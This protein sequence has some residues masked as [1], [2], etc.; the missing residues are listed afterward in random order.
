[1][2]TVLKLPL[3]CGLPDPVMRYV[4]SKSMFV[5]TNS[6]SDSLRNNREFAVLSS[7][8]MRPCLTAISSLTG[9]LIETLDVM[10]ESA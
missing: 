9:A 3:I 7:S 5:G 2:Q 1:M 8:I 4:E 6:R 10:L